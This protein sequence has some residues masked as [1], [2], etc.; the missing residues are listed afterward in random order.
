MNSLMERWVHTC[1]CEPLDR[2]LIWNLRHLRHAL[3]E[4]ENAL[5]TAIALTKRC[6]RPFHYRQGQCRDPVAEGQSSAGR[7]PAR[8]RSTACAAHSGRALLRAM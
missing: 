2:T 1:R 6:S 4:Y 7:R 3:Y 8:T 5:Q